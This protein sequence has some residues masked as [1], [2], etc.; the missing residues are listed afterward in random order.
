MPWLWVFLGSVLADE[1]PPELN[2]GLQSSHGCEAGP[3]W[4]KPLNGGTASL[5]VDGDGRVD[6]VSVAPSDLVDE[7][8]ALVWY[9][10][11]D[12]GLYDPPS[13]LFEEVN[14]AVDV[15]TGD[16]DRDGRTDLV[17]SGEVDGV[18]GIFA[19]HNQGTLLEASASLLSAT[20]PAGESPLIEL[21]HL[22]EDRVL[23]LWANPSPLHSGNVAAV[24]RG[25]EFRTWTPLPLPIL[26][27]GGLYRLVDLDDDGMT[28]TVARSDYKASDWGP[29]IVNP[30]D[31]Y[32]LTP[33]KLPLPERIP[34]EPVRLYAD[35]PPS[36]VAT[37]WGAYSSRIMLAEQTAP[38]TFDEPRT[39]LDDALLVAVGDLDG[40]GDD[41]VLAKREFYGNVFVHWNQSGILA[42]GVPLGLDQEHPWLLSRIVDVDLDG[43]DDL[44]GY[45]RATVCPSDPRWSEYNL[46]PHPRGPPHR[47]THA[48]H[49][50]GLRMPRGVLCLTPD[51]TRL[52]AH[53]GC[54]ASP[55][56]QEGQPRLRSSAGVSHA[57]CVGVFA[58]CTCRR[59]RIGGSLG[60]AA[61]VGLLDRGPVVQP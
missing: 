28:D 32:R 46:R 58:R 17:V 26:H 2:W 10:L 60:I 54:R 8:G 13:S 15:A 41:D 30:L 6:R 38:W 40:D 49:P 24:A 25:P 22:D 52:D 42:E 27:D 47:R 9:R 18:D 16:L 61:R 59:A 34:W 37:A 44:L 19:Y 7:L 50:T 35:G 20:L 12:T 57:K 39:W 31:P 33:R 5:D 51:G 11:D 1:P 14:R 48:A 43:D 3:Q 23:D 4:H 55:C 29:T 45:H 36:F 56:R 53:A 21:V